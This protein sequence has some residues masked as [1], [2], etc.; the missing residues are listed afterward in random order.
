MGIQRKIS[1]PMWS[2]E[3]ERERERKETKGWWEG[4]GD[5]TS[6]VVNHLGN[7]ENES[8]RKRFFLLATSTN[9]C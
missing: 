3:R 4:K 8:V 2:S 1:E 5:V 7:M 9:A 6:Q